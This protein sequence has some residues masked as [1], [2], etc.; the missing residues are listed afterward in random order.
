MFEKQCFFSSSFTW[1]DSS[2]PSRKFFWCLS[3]FFLLREGICLKT[4]CAELFQYKRM[5]VTSI[6]KLQNIALF[7]RRNKSVLSNIVV[8]GGW[9]MRYWC[10][11]SDTR[12]GLIWRRSLLACHR[13]RCCCQY[14]FTL[15]SLPL[16]EAQRCAPSFL[17]GAYFVAGVDA[18]VWWERPW[19]SNK[20]MP[21]MSK[22]SRL[23]W[24]FPRAVLCIHA[25][26]RFQ[27]NVRSYCK[28]VLSD[29]RSV[30]SSAGGP[31]ARPADVHPPH[32]T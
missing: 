32:S 14:A 16:T 4:H 22:K 30:V 13:E 1:F 3:L 19:G 23:I 25:T 11:V 24:C 8:R 9:T 15:Q 29:Q 5:H 2:F 26:C 10:L 27:R 31:N 17:M 28:W 7:T 21:L 12:D 6:Y 18:D 20:W